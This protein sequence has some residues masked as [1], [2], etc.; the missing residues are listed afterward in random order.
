MPVLVNDPTVRLRLSTSI[1]PLFTSGAVMFPLPVMMPAAPFN[2]VAVPL[3]FAP[4]SRI[5]PLLVKPAPL[6]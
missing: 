2:S 3:M 1:T 5:A 4:L 6:S